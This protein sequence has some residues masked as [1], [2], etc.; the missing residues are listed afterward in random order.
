MLKI[1]PAPSRLGLPRLSFL[2]LRKNRLIH[3]GHFF[4]FAPKLM[5]LV[6]TS[7]FGRRLG[8]FCF[9]LHQ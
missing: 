8:V 3:C 2:S 6:V 5:K 9:F 7:Q 4:S 1:A